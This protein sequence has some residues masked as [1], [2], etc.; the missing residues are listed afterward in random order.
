MMLPCENCGKCEQV[1]EYSLYADG[2]SVA[3]VICGECGVAS[4]RAYDESPADAVA[5]AK[6]KWDAYRGRAR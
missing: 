6:V 5:L 1:V 3:K 2:S 4:P